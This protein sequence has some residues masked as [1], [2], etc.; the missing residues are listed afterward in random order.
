MNKRV[1]FSRESRCCWC[2]A[3]IRYGEGK[4]EGSTAAGEYLKRRLVGEVE[5]ECTRSNV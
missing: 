1:S 3:R 5:K 2:K 4:Q